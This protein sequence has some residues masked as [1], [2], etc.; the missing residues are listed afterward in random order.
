MSV[1]PGWGGQPFIAS[2]PDKVS[3]LR[4]LAPAAVIEVDGGVDAET[5]GGVAEAGASLFVAGSAVFGDPEPA[6]AY[7]RIAA[8]QARNSRIRR[9]LGFAFVSAGLGRRPDPAAHVLPRLRR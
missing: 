9:S 1:N 5:V 7:R 8:A 4:G 3:R 6:E 2:S